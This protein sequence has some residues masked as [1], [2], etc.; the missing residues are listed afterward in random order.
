MENGGANHHPVPSLCRPAD[1]L[2]RIPAMTNRDDLGVLPPSRWQPANA[3]GAT[4]ELEAAPA[5]AM[6]AI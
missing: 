4:V 6:A 1:I 5:A 3:A 2:E